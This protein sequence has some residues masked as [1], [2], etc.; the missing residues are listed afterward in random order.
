MADAL[1]NEVAVMFGE[2]ELTM[3]ATV[4]SL[5]GIEA[6]LRKGVYRLYR[7]I[8]AGE[9]GM[10]EIVTIL[11]HG[12]KAGGNEKKYNVEQVAQEVVAMGFDNASAAALS[13]LTQSMQG[14]SLGK[15]KQATT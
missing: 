10:G 5:R 6:D 1:R 14:Q 12:L 9:F 4:E 3:R 7:D 2:V 8:A 11:F 15:S 13:F